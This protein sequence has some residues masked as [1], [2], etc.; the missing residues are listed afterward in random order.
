MRGLARHRSLL[1]AVLLMLSFYVF[2][3]SWSPSSRA[4]FEGSRFGEFDVRL[5]ET[6][7]R[8]NA[9]DDLRNDRRTWAPKRQE[10]ATLRDDETLT[11][12][13]DRQNSEYNVHHQESLQENK[14]QS[15][16][17]PVDRQKL[18]HFKGDNNEAAMNVYDNPP[19]PQEELDDPESLN[20]T[21]F[22]DTGSNESQ[23]HA[24]LTGT[25][26]NDIDGST[27]SRF[28]NVQTK[29]LWKWRPDV[30]IVARQAST[31]QL[32]NFLLSIHTV[33]ALVQ[34][35]DGHTVAGL[36]LVSIEPHR[37]DDKFKKMDPETAQEWQR[38]IESE[39]YECHFFSE[40]GEDAGSSRA[41]VNQIQF[42]PP[43]DSSEFFLPRF[44]TEY[45]C[46]DAVELD[47]GSLPS[48][49][50]FRRTDNEHEDAAS[51]GMDDTEDVSATLLDYAVEISVPGAT[52]ND[53]DRRNHPEWWNPH[54]IVCAAPTFGKSTV[55]WI[56][57]EWTT[58]YRHQG[59]GQFVFYQNHWRTQLKS[60]G[61]LA[62]SGMGWDH[63]IMGYH[64]TVGTGRI[65]T[66]NDRSLDGTK[67][68]EDMVRTIAYSDCLMRASLQWAQLN[69]ERQKGPGD[70]DLSDDVKHLDPQA[71][72]SM[73]PAD[74]TPVLFVEPTDIVTLTD[75]TGQW[76]IGDLL[77]T[78][79]TT[80]EDNSWRIALLDRVGMCVSC[81]DV[82]P[83]RPFN[84][85]LRY[86]PIITERCKYPLRWKVDP[87][88]GL[89]QRGTPLRRREGVVTLM[90]VP[91]ESV[92][93]V[94]EDG[95][96]GLDVV[97]DEAEILTEGRA[98]A[99]DIE[100]EEE[101]GL[102]MDTNEDAIVSLTW[103]NRDMTQSGYA[104]QGP[105]FAHM[106]ALNFGQ[107]LQTLEA[108]DEE[109]GV[110]NVPPYRIRNPLTYMAAYLETSFAGSAPVWDTLRNQMNQ[111]QI[112]EIGVE[113]K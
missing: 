51:E 98:K 106:A 76:T 101:K 9:A 94:S 39:T 40:N 63:L 92:F 26:S 15:Q 75:R 29:K 112:E 87:A 86:P 22:R 41:V 110:D 96:L 2:T 102:N 113:G 27:G 111:W 44:M 82:P 58:Y 105:D 65:I 14:K 45:R 77:E 43:H 55:W 35:H 85:L 66:V 13:R 38:G 10:N 61:L 12:N 69:E 97:R 31:V 32:S 73:S 24:H 104:M 48:Y 52:G 47:D 71:L 64:Q 62:D 3:K 8:K 1:C 95:P 28:D 107:P 11:E 103:N 17:R 70:A 84:P 79:R 7:N 91:V 59:W 89:R 21:G 42:L 4:I 88:W 36:A 56:L 57:Q 30:T 53:V 16:D 99:D 6:P 90:K 93:V 18:D 20:D 78:V 34:V 5:R 109:L 54:S 80:T 49:A 33:N 81:A 50:L 67:I 72:T 25:H 68:P 83:H 19:L 100:G 37:G 108:I 23:P 74:P 46:E 60:E